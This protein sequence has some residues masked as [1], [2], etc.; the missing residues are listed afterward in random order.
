MRRRG[1]LQNIDVW[2]PGNEDE[3]TGQGTLWSTCKARLIHSAGFTPKWQPEVQ[4]ALAKTQSRNDN[5]VGESK[6]HGMK[7]TNQLI[8]LLLHV[9]LHYPKMC[10]TIMRNHDFNRGDGAFHENT[11]RF[12]FQ[13]RVRRPLHRGIEHCGKRSCPWLKVHFTLWTPRAHDQ[14]AFVVHADG[15]SVQR[16]CYLRSRLRGRTTLPPAPVGE[17]TTPM[18]PS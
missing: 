16:C 10:S 4:T 2:R 18:T 3:A 11:C 12:S 14:T 13:V 9:L 15:W 6:Q 8:N 1:P 5:K 17:A 7:K